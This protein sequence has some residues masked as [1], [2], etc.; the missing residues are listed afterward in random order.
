M[1]SDLLGIRTGVVPIARQ[2]FGSNLRRLEHVG[3]WNIWHND[4]L[5]L[6][7][8][9]EVHKLCI[10]VAVLSDACRQGSGQISVGRYTILMACSGWCCL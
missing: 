5:L 4:H 10:S 2:H 6:L 9:G 1:G 3:A 7:L 8:S